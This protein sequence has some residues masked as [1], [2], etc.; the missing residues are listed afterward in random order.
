MPRLFVAVWPPQEVLDRIAALD[1][2]EVPGLRWTTRD[3]WHVTLRFL[4]EVSD[5]QPVAQALDALSRLSPAEV[6]LGPATG[7]FGQRILHVP[8]EGLEAAARAVVQATAHLG[9]P[10]DD[11]P[12][13]GHL[14]LAR[15]AKGAN[16]DLRPL[17]GVHLSGSWVVEDVCLV[18]SR[19]SSKGAS[20]HVLDRFPLANR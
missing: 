20:Y 18:E 15:V 1:R 7:R 16:V 6:C 19:L 3:Q 12:F 4:G 10:P 8:V 17:T 2:P 11:R 13:S 14:T 9:R 5:V